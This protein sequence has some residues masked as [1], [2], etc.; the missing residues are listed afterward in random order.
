MPQ[1]ELTISSYKFGSTHL[2]LDDLKPGA[3]YEYVLNQEII[4]IAPFMTTV[5]DKLFKHYDIRSCNKNGV[6]SIFH[7]I[8]PED[9]LKEIPASS[10]RLGTGTKLIFNNL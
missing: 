10:F 8:F 2:I 7:H 3:T 6:D 1:T 9:D 5:D 4:H